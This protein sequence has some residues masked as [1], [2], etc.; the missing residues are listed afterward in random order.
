LAAS[1]GH[2]PPRLRRV[3]ADFSAVEVLPMRLQ[4]EVI[5]A[6]NLVRSGPGRW[7]RPT[8]AS[9]RP[10]PMSRPSACCRSAVL[11]SVTVTDVS[12]RQID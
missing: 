3:A 5:G 2:G 9:G 1:R 7:T 4:D 8:C 10:S 12:P 6:L 11:A